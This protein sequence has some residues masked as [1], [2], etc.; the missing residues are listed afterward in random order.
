[1]SDLIEPLKSSE[2]D[3]ENDIDTPKMTSGQMLVAGFSG[4]FAKVEAELS[5]F[6]DA[7][8]KLQLNGL[9]D[10]IDLSQEQ[11]FTVSI[12]YCV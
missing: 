5:G 10:S 3:V 4:L 9:T 8:R 11:N 2:V 7:F 12:Y 6:Y 1:M